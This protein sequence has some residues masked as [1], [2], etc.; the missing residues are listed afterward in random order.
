MFDLSNSEE[1]NAWRV[2]YKIED[3]ERITIAQYLDGGPFNLNQCVNDNYP[4]YEL[5]GGYL[6]SFCLTEH[7]FVIPTSTFILD[8]C[9]TFVTEPDD[10]IM[11][12]FLYNYNFTTDL[13]TR[14]VV[15]SRDTNEVV[16]EF[17]TPEGLFIT[18]Q[19]ESRTVV[20]RFVVNMS[21]W[22]LIERIDLYPSG[23]Q[24]VEF[25]TINYDLYNAKPYRY[26][27]MVGFDPVPNSL[28][29]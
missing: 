22:T 2:L 16:G 27:Y 29:K 26:A 28:I 19:G 18:H 23:Y 15:I 1:V 3:D 14:F 9:K 5:P 8:V 24:M 12:F 6:H 21:D 10:P 11:P 20:E 13:P 4:E 25:S 7:Y 17:S